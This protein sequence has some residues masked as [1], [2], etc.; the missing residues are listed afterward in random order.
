MPDVVNKKSGKIIF[1]EKQ[2]Q[3]VTE[4]YGK[5]SSE[6]NKFLTDAAK[7]TNQSSARRARTCS[8]ALEKLLKE[9][10]R[11]SIK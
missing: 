2:I 6:M 10:R 1:T 8:L 3:E 5:V 7:H 9:Y 11:I 4:L